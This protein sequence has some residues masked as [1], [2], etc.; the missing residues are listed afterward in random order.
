[1]RVYGSPNWRGKRWSQEFEIAHVK[2]VHPVFPDVRVVYINDGKNSDS[3]LDR[4]MDLLEVFTRA[5]HKASHKG[6]ESL[7]RLSFLS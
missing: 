7:L 4:V 1:M 2:G 5:A 3:G 6:I